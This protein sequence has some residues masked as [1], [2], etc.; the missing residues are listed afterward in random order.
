[1]R[2]EYSSSVPQGEWVNGLLSQ[3][4]SIAIDLSANQFTFII[5]NQML[6]FFASTCRRILLLWG[7]VQYMMDWKLLL[8]W[9]NMR[10]KFVILPIARLFHFNS[11]WKNFFATATHHFA[12]YFSG[13]GFFNEGESLSFIFWKYV[14]S[15]TRGVNCS[16][17]TLRTGAIHTA[18]VWNL[19]DSSFP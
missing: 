15:W 6:P 7:L 5:L 14:C 11:F 16:K 17:L 19:H 3:L 12:V 10:F 8:C 13:F 4:N 18:T 2:T 9:R 1:M